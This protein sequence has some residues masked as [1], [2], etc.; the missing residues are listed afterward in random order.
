MSVTLKKFS[1]VEV[2]DVEMYPINAMENKAPV[3]VGD[4][5]HQQPTG[6]SKEDPFLNYHGFIVFIKGMP[7]ECIEEVISVKITAVKQRYAF[8]QFIGRY[9]V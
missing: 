5:L 8:G 4:V 6:K 7:E 9:D 1:V 3:R 2:M